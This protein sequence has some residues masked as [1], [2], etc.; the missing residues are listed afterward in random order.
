MRKSLK[1][2]L[3][4]A[5]SALAFVAAGFGVSA[6]KTVDVAKAEGELAITGRTLNVSNN[7]NVVFLI[8]A[9]VGDAEKVKVVAK[10]VNAVDG[11]EEAPVI[12]SA[13]GTYTDESTGTVYDQYIYKGVEAKEMPNV[14][15]AY[16]YHVDNPTVL[17]ATR[18]FSIIEY[19]HTSLASGA[20][21]KLEDLI[22]A[23]LD[24]GE[25]AAAF[26]NQTLPADYL[27]DYKLWE[28]DES[29]NATFADGFDYS[30][31]YVGEVVNLK[32]TTGYVV[33]DGMDGFTKNEDDTY[34]YTVSESLP[35][36]SGVFVEDEDISAFDKVTA[37]K[38]SLTL[39]FSEVI[40]GT[41]KELPTETSYPGVSITWSG[42]GVTDNSITFNTVGSVTLTATISCEGTE[43]QTK[44][45]TITV[46]E[47]PYPVE[48]KAYALKTTGQYATK[49]T[50]NNFLSISAEENDAES[51]YFK[52]VDDV[53]YIYY[54]MD[55]TSI[56]YV[57]HSSSTSLKF[58][59]GTVDGDVPS[60]CTGWTLDVNSK[61]I[62]S[63]VDS[64]RKLG[65]NA[66]SPR[67]STYG[68]TDTQFSAVWFEEIRELTA[69]EKIAKDMEALTMLG[70]VTGETTI[71]LVTVGSK[72][73]STITWEITQDDN[74]L[75][76]RV[77]DDTITIAKYTGEETTSVTLTAAFELE[78][79][80]EDQTKEFTITVNPVVEEE[81]G[82]GGDEPV[83]PTT[84]TVKIADYASDN[85]WT[86][87]TK[88]TTINIVKD[89]ITATATGTD[90]NTGKYY[91][92]G[93]EWR[94]YQTGAPTIKIS[95]SGKTIISVKITYNISN[96]GVLTLNG[97][98]IGSNTVVEVNAE[99]ITFGVG[100]T[101]TKTNGQVKITAIEV[102]YK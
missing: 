96:S 73:G 51:F 37:E 19:A 87:G 12:L 95:A 65:Y 85:G 60:G 52:K 48:G 42:D 17:S 7:V 10:E 2:I 89:I 15:Y 62:I 23:T 16:A 4:A 58:V 14:V 66:T 102:V 69:D 44:E 99:S 86:N 1:R 24:Y 34:S 25:A 91:T 43:S 80:T 75:I 94:T 101:G 55:E 29:T 100:N 81:P 27:N 18:K 21:S 50:A 13:T 61:K 38:E 31:V 26:E 47:N 67:F 92:S 71:D 97:S 36:M 8:Q 28:L 49:P 70:E 72:Y 57:E 84:V 6:L 54:M 9:E 93:Y 82:I 79:M 33:A 83:E 35:D 77:D 20:D 46:K 45:F 22:K 5:L 90:D 11:T 41:T 39:D 59:N 30:Y 64:N 74:G 76:T 63:N 3:T 53:Y 68:V 56:K 78:G 32:P 98:N 88:Y 40:V